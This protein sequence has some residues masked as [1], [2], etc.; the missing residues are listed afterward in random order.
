MYVGM[1]NTISKHT[2]K[3][4]GRKKRLETRWANAPDFDCF[5]AGLRAL[6]VRVP[7]FDRL[8]V[9]V[10]EAERAV[11]FVFV[12]T[13]LLWLVVMLVMLRVVYHAAD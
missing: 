13:V 2:A 4:T 6:A 1:L 12:M 9:L 11:V 8:A 10:R 5:A 3:A 7:V